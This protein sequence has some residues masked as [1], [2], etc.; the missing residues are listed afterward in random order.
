MRKYLRIY[1]ECLIVAWNQ[2]VAYRLNFVLVSLIMLLGNI[3]FPVFTIM[4]YRTGSSYP[5]WS[6]FEVLL[7][8]SI[9]TMADG[10]SGMVTGGLLWATL[11]HVQEGSLDTVLL[12]PVN[13]LWF[14]VTSTM[15][16][17]NIGLI[18]GGG[19]L[20]GISVAKTGGVTL[21][22]FMGS[23]VLFLS[24]VA[25][26]AG[27][28]FLMSAMTFKWV[29]NSRMQDIF[30]SVKMFGKYPIS[31][32]PKSIQSLLTFCIPVA[33][34][35]YFP[36]RVLL[37]KGSMGIGKGMFMVIPCFIFMVVCTK[38]YNWMVRLYEG[39]GG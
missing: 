17:T 2:A 18:L 15:E 39:V 9:F 37:K 24:G 20:Y 21:V 4:I 16:P 14:M 33:V 5:G 26:L 1:K 12:K 28:S 34:V 8:Q 11:H 6:F 25:V 27:I 3:L 30:E 31:I 22:S 13:T 29:G 23:L 7:L 36:A 10:V 38:I 19:I 35:A 32:F